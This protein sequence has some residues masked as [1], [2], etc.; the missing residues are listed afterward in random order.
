MKDLRG[1]QVNTFVDKNNN[2]WY[3]EEYVKTLVEQ[4]YHSGITEGLY[5][6]QRIQLYIMIPDDE[7]CT[8]RTKDKYE[9]K[10]LDDMFQNVTLDNI[11]QNVLDY[12]NDI[13][14]DLAIQIKNR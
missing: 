4:S 11:K 2:V 7:N 5:K 8:F 9:A 3:S 12:I 6:G 1:N 13:F 10:S 14:K